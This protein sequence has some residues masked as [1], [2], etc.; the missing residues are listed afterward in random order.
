MTLMTVRFTYLLTLALWLVNGSVAQ[1]GGPKTQRQD[2]TQPTNNNRW[3]TLASP[4][5]DFI[6][7]FPAKP[8]RQPDAVAPSGTSRGYV[9]TKDSLIYRFSYVDTGFNPADYD[10]NQLPPNFGRDLIEHAEQKGSTVISSRLLRINVFEYEVLHPRQGER[11]QMLHW[12]ERHAIRYGRQYTLSCGSTIPNRK[13]D[14]VSCRRF[15]ESF[16]VLRPPQP[17]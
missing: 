14:S 11:G 8:E 10:A 12:L 15:F 13:V 16:R 3:H 17:Q 5:K 4:D 9:L 1:T 7:E 2:R 6:I